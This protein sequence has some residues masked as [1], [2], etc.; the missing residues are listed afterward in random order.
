MPSEIY[1]GYEFYGSQYARFGTAVAAEIRRKVYGID[2]GQQGWRSMDE[3]RQIVEILRKY[4]CRDVID[5]ACGS[6]GPSLA[7]AQAIGCNLTGVDVEQNAITAALG[8]AASLGK[9]DSTQ[10]IVA[11]CGKQ[12]PFPDVSFDAVICI[13]AILHFA[14]R[15]DV[16]GDW[17]RLLRP[18]GILIFADAAVVT[19]AI[20]KEE[21]IIRAS[22]GSFVCVPVGY[23]EA[24]LQS[25]GFKVIGSFDTTKIEAEIACNLVRVREKHRTALIREEGAEWF[26]SRQKFLSVTSEL[27]NN[28]KLSRL[29]YMASKL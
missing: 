2:I 27:A 16:M 10:F 5:V 8:F 21:I 3:Q 6:G 15:D 4:S 1:Q 11:D 20:S 29:F 25:I 28:R 9:S 24:A 18:N 26:Q 14:H 23:N 22:Q 19:G 7:I 13:D 12:L 17:H